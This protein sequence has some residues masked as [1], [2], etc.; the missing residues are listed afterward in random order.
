MS[1]EEPQIRAMS[2]IIMYPDVISPLSVILMPNILNKGTQSI[3]KIFSEY[4]D[5]DNRLH[6]LYNK[7]E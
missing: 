6:A 5:W 2:L 1:S 7:F 3:K 4:D